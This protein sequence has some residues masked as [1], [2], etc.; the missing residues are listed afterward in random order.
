LIS[1][2][3]RTVHW[4]SPPRNSES[5]APSYSLVGR[6][7]SDGTLTCLCPNYEDPLIQKGLVQ[8]T[9]GAT[10]LSGGWKGASTHGLG[11]D[12]SGRDG[13]DNRPNCA[14]SARTPSGFLRTT[15]KAL[16]RPYAC[17]CGGA[18]ATLSPPIFWLPTGRSFRS[19]TKDFVPNVPRPAFALLLPGRLFRL[20]RAR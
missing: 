14:S 16:A 13:A 15:Q 9:K 20:L 11:M 3:L 5:K 4:R 6:T 8:K 7:L 10:A 2:A 19:A 18:G 1:A 17:D 12:G